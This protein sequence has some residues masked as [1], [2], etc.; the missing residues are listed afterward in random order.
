MK[1]NSFRLVVLAV[2]LFGFG[3]VNAHFMWI[4][5]TKSEASS[6]II[7]FFG[8]GHALPME[9]FLATEVGT[10]DL[11]TFELIGPDSSRTTLEAPDPEMHASF[12]TSSG[13]VARS[14]DLGAY[15]FSY[16]EDSLQ[17]TYRL[18]A[19]SK[20]YY[21]AQYIDKKGQ[22]RIARKP[23]DEINDPNGIETVV[24]AVRN[25]YL[26]NAYM[27]VGKWTTPTPTGHLAEIIPETNLHTVRP[28]DMVRFRLMFDGKPFYD[29]AGLQTLDFLNPEFSATNGPDAHLISSYVSN[30]V[31][32]FRVPNSGQ[33][34]VAALVKRDV[35]TEPSLKELRGKVLKDGYYVTLTFN[36][37]Q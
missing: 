27:T 32:Q 15:K 8:F 12:N 16:N 30:G 3:S 10:I 4:N 35:D 28:G 33:W 1:K 9:D 2:V 36:V 7:S 5:T 18:A 26:S 21:F 20:Y 13:L 24:R 19:A 34:M 14:G 6:L 23:L 31:A 37:S 22:T 29:P 25:S 17:G 11:E